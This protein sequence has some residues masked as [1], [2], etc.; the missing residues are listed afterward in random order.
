M[1]RTRNL[2]LPVSGG[3][4]SAATAVQRD[5]MQMLGDAARQE[6]DRNLA[7]Q[8]LQQEHEAGNRQLGATLGAAAGFAI[9]GPAGA[10]LGSALGGI[11]GGLF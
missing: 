10:M 7:N 9:G 6:Q 2:G 3:L 11:A 1:A 4:A 5:G 8:R